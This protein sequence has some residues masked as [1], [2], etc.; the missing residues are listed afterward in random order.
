VTGFIDNPNDPY[1][2]IRRAIC[3]HIGDLTE[4]VIIASDEERSY[5]VQ[6]VGHDVDDTIVLHADWTSSSRV[7]A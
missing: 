3:R 7:T 2:V 4:F 1:G 5:F 6:A